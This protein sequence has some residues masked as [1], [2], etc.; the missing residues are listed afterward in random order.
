M[1]TK[2]ISSYC[3]SLDHLTRLDDAIKLCASSRCCLIRIFP[4]ATLTSSLTLTKTSFSTV[5]CHEVSVSMLL[6]FFQAQKHA[7]SPFSFV[8]GHVVCSHTATV[9]ASEAQKNRQARISSDFATQSNGMPFHRLYVGNMHFSIHETDLKNLDEAVLNF[10]VCRATP[11]KTRPTP[12][13]QPSKRV[14]R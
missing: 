4:P 13:S 10:S 5:I 9:V 14:T 2:V 12:L 7:K 11:G 6:V 1:I 8:D 3:L